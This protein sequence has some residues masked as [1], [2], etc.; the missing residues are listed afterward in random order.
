[1]RVL[2][3]ARLVSERFLGCGVRVRRRFDEAFFRYAHGCPDAYGNYLSFRFEGVL[4]W[5]GILNVLSPTHSPP[6]LSRPAGR[7]RGASCGRV[8]K[9]GKSELYCALPSKWL[10][11]RLEAHKSIF[12]Q[13]QKALKGWNDLQRIENPC[14]QF[15]GNAPLRAFFPPFK[16]RPHGA[17]S[18]PFRTKGG[19][20]GLGER[21]GIQRLKIKNAAS[22][23]VNASSHADQIA[24]E[25]CKDDPKN[26]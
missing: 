6:P 22:N 20:E 17:V 25:P 24:S 10:P 5:V 19:G 4:D 7:K 16:T 15:D 8:S 14:A 13:E 21:G 18:P 2:R 3:C 11:C 1:M 23:R 26:D 9:G 12:A